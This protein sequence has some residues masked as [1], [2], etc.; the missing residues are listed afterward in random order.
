MLFSEGFC[1]KKV[2]KNIKI[3]Y[4]I[5]V[6]ILHSVQGRNHTNEVKN[7]A[8][9]IARVRVGEATHQEI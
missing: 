2:G 6:L 1:F 5:Q 9:D 7:S 8:I 4:T 3:P